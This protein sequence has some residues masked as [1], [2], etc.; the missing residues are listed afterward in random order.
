MTLYTEIHYGNVWKNLKFLLNYKICVKRV[1]K[2][3]SAARIE[4]TLS[5]FFENK[6]GL[7]QGDP[8][9]PILFNLALQ[10]VIQSIKLV[11]SGI[12]IHKE[13]LN[14]LA[15]AD[16]MALIGKNG[17]EIRKLSVDMENIARKFGL[18]INQEKT[19]YM[20]V[21][22]KNS[23][24]K[25]KIKC[26]KIKNYKFERVEN[27]KYLVVILNEDNNNQI[28]LQEKIKNSNKTYF[29]L[30]KFFKNKNVSK[31]LNLRLK[32]TIIDKTLTY[33]SETWTQTKRDRRQLNIFERKVCRRILGPVYDNEKENWRILA[34]K[35]IYASVKKPTVIET[36]RLNRLRWF[37][38]VQKMEENRIPKRALYM[39]LGR[40]RLRGR[41]RNRCQDEVR[42]DGRI[43]GGEGWKEKVLTERNG[44][45]S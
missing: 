26:L 27:F 38:H 37:G 34:D 13:Q 24:K 20:V 29:M 11:P 6:T 45:S 40:T 35:E 18:Q 9:S 39:N 8:F 16:D 5:T 28:D 21:E 41:P 23:L 17:I 32:N 30:Q 7:K 36:M 2:T 14:I 12:K 42:K 10:K 25:N 3:R 1:Q 22:R 33:A 19:K 44:R 15:Y 43:V 31:K 4:G